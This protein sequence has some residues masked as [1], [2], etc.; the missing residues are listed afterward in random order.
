M[1]VDALFK[2]A[3]KGR[4]ARGLQDSGFKSLSDFLDKTYPTERIEKPDL[5]LSQLKEWVDAYREANDRSFPSHHSGAIKD[6]DGQDTG[7]NWKAVD[8]V[9]RAAA[10]GSPARGLQGC[11][12]NSLADFLD[13]TYPTERQQQASQKPTRLRGDDINPLLGLLE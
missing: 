3:A 2:A 8:A 11:G 12:F 13:K 9:L 7:E 10:K 6:R 4:P 1:A 5:S